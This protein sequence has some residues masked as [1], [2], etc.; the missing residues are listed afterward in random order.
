M[1][2]RILVTAVAV[3][4]FNVTFVPLHNEKVQRDRIYALEHTVIDTNEASCCFGGVSED[5]LM[6]ELSKYPE[7]K[8]IGG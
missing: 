3:T 7:F 6:V 2:G 5:K 4:M 1:F 8:P